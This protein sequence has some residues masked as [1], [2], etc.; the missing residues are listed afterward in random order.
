MIFPSRR[1]H[2]KKPEKSQR[3]RPQSSKQRRREW[4]PR[5]ICQ[6]DGPKFGGKKGEDKNVIT[7]TMTKTFILLSIF[8]NPVTLIMIP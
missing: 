4:R 8:L 3:S 2:I 7:Q 6:V 1:I 5:I